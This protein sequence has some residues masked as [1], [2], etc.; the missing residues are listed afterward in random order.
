MSI[1]QPGVASYLSLPWSLY[2]RKR[3]DIYKPPVPADERLL[4]GIFLPRDGLPQA[5]GPGSRVDP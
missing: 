4:I 2:L 3:E 1:P 5:G